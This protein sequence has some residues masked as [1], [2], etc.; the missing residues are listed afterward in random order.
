MS[1][2]PRPDFSMRQEVSFAESSLPKT[3]AVALRHKRRI[4]REL[5]PESAGWPFED[6]V[7]IWLPGHWNEDVAK[8]HTGSGPEMA[9]RFDPDQLEHLDDYYCEKLRQRLV[10]VD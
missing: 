5:G 9:K 2:I 4:A 3:M 10:G 7:L 6:R 8:Y 1:G